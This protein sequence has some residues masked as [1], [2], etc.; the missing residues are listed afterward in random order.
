LRAIR[1]RQWISTVRVSRHLH[2]RRRFRE[3]KRM[4]KS[5]FKSRGPSEPHE[6][7]PAGETAR[8]AM[9]TM[10]SVSVPSVCS[11]VKNYAGCEN[12]VITYDPDFTSFL[13]RIR[14]FVCASS[15]RSL[16]VL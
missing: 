10:V 7:T 1:Y 13:M 5:Y 3:S 4:A 9:K 14:L 2:H 11:V 16:N 8:A 12:P 6:R 15:S